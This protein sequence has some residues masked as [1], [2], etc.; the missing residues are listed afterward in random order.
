M[1]A[2]VG[3]LLATGPPAPPTRSRG[4]LKQN[5]ERAED[6]LG[7]VRR[8]PAAAEERAAACLPHAVESHEVDAAHARD[9]LAL[10]GGAV[11]GEEPGRADPR[12]VVPVAG[13]PDHGSDPLGREIE[14]ARRAQACE[15]L[16]AP[17]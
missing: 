6:M 17:V 15:L 16:L 8:R 14:R 9:S 2:E 12:E 10:V 11:P 3:A 7:D 4:V 1:G 13:G 5:L